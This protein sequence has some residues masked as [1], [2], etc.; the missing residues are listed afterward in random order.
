MFSVYMGQMAEKI[1][2]KNRLD[3]NE[4]QVGL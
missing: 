2:M 3:Y 1:I 4:K